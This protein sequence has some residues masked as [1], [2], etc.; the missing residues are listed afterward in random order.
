MHESVPANLSLDWKL[1]RALYA[2]TRSPAWEAVAYPDVADLAR[3]LEVTR[4]TIYRRLRLWR[5]RGFI[6]GYDFFPNP[7]L[8]G[9]GLLHYRVE[10]RFTSLQEGFLDRLESVEGVFVANESLGDPYGITAIADSQASQA[11]RVRSLSRIEGVTRVS[12]PTP[13]WLP[14]SAGRLRRADFQLISVLREEPEEPFAALAAKLRISSQTFARRYNALRANRLLLVHRS[15]DFSRLPG[16]VAFLLVVVRNRAESRA[17]SLE[18]RRRLPGL[19]EDVSLSRP[20]FGPFEK[21]NF[22]AQVDSASDLIE[23]ESVISAVPGVVRVLRRFPRTERSY[24]RWFD[25]RIEQVL[26]TELG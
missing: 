23:V 22:G 4:N 5:S 10:G 8:F 11:G 9:V 14:H 7:A 21:L 19:L 15:V 13:V 6:R 16:T 17:I 1:L 2:K 26:R 3:D 20:P 18:I 24:P 25:N 12:S